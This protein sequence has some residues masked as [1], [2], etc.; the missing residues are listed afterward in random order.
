MAYRIVYEPEIK[1]HVPTKRKSYSLV[2]YVVSLVLLVVIVV[3][4]N[5]PTVKCALRYILLPGDP[6]ITL[7]AGKEL[8]ETLKN[9]GT[10]RESVTVF[11]ME[12]LNGSMR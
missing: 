7:S 4:V 5:L 1:S 2:K 8:V 3:F 6:D 10:V 9:G 11:C 12:I